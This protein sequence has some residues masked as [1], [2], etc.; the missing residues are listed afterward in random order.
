MSVGSGVPYNAHTGNG[1]TTVFAYGFTLLDA[2]DLV[3]TIDGVVT[4]AYTVSGLGVAA[5]GSITFSSAP[6]NGTAVLLQ[7]VIQLV[8]STEYPTN[9]DLLAETVNGDFD[10]LWM[11]VQNVDSD[12]TRSLRVPEVGVLPELPA[13]ADR[14]DKLLSFD[15]DGNPSVTAPSA[16]TATA[17]AADLLDSSTATK[18]PAMVGMGPSVAYENGPRVA[19]YL[20][21]Y[22]TPLAYT[23]CV[24][25]GV[26]D[27]S[28][29][30][31]AALAAGK[32]EIVIPGGYTFLVDGNLS[33]PTGVRI[34]GEGKIIK[35]AGTI[36]PIFLLADG[37]IDITFEGITI[38]G[39][40]ASF[41]AGNGVPAILGHL[42]QW[43]KIHHVNFENIID[44]GVKLRDSGYLE[45]IGGRFFNIGEN[46]IELK[47]YD[48]DVRTGLAYAT[49]RPA[50]EGGHRIE[51]AWFGQID[52]GTV[53]G[54]GDGC[55]ILIA[56]GI[57][58]GGTAYPMQG[59]GIVNCDFHQVKRGVWIENN[60]AGCQSLDIITANNRFRGD[61]NGFP[62]LVYI[63]I[64]YIG[65]IRGKISNNSITNLGNFAPASDKCCGVIL[66]GLST[67][68]D[69]LDNTIMDTT[70][71][72]DR[73]DYAIKLN[74]G[75]R[76]RLIGN[77]MGGGSEGQIYIDA[78]VTN[79]ESHNNPGA[80]DVHS[81]GETIA[82]TFKLSNIPGTATTAL[83]PEGY[84][85]GADL[86][87][88]MP[89]RL[90]GVSARLNAAITSGVG[91][92]TIKP[93]T[94]GVNRSNLDITNTDFS[95]TAATKNIGV[96][97][98][99]TIAAGL[100]VRFDAVTA[101]FTPTTADLIVV[102]IFDTT[103]KN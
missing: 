90:V 103:N 72:T 55:G 89:A 1:L 69:V 95:G 46:G 82:V 75:D 78:S 61:V 64:G 56:T 38:D 37:G 43:V 35:K 84:E 26:A 66:G 12:S 18:G 2:D 44:V 13:A 71:N 74:A 15:S 73:M 19:N 99:V 27:D 24:G 6:A 94:N 45:L 97:S 31:A 39:A 91:T 10:R 42:N 77:T 81:W 32:K 68:I 36:K 52:N 93:Y 51:G 41:S 11:A 22:V 63:G 49:A 62:G 86:V 28:S 34:V 80:Q 7:R 54:S 59:A 3:V 76:Y 96:T 92:L 5:G 79:L 23:G 16:G 8:R 14:A 83:T 65:A 60:D 30:V 17:L 87:F 9:G 25:D 102:A 33:V 67:Y 4:S 70:G 21:S 29:Y 47:N 20:K 40:R 53:D 50:C 58:Y 85:D 88:P 48:A 100:P 101:G 57:P 98:G